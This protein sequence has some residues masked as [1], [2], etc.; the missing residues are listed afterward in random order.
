MEVYTRF[1]L[2]FVA[3]LSEILPRTEIFLFS[4]RPKRITPMLKSNRPW[5]GLSNRDTLSTGGGTD[6]G[7]SFMGVL[8][9]RYSGVLGPRTR[10]MIVSD[11]WDRGDS[12]TLVR[13]M[14]GFRRRSAGMVWLNPLAGDAG[15]EPL[16]VGLQAALPYVDAHLPFR[17]LHDVKKLT[18]WFMRSLRSPGSGKGR[19]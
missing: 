8:K 4:T 3:G 1:L 12:K 2:A 6:I 19:V 11:G 16:T 9:G 10:I 15:Y 13:A 17:N 7:G 18:A 5:L 14:D